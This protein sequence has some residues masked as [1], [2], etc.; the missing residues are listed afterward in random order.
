MVNNDLNPN[1]ILIELKKLNKN[2]EKGRHPFH[3][4]WSNF[5]R[6]TF[7][8]L[9]AIFGTLVLASVVIYLFS[10]FN[11]TQSISKWIESTMSQ[12]NWNKIVTPQLQTIQEKSD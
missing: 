3:L 11:F 6:G 1:E 4:F 7:Y 9:G 12:I 10:R 8:S 2:L 5:L